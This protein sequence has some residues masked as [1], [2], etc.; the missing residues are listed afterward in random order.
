MEFLLDCVE[1]GAEY[2]VCEATELNVSLPGAVLSEFPIDGM[3]R[4]R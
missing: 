1:E 4:S 2:V 3:M